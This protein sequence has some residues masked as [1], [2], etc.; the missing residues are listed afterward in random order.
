[1]LVWNDL[2][3]QFDDLKQFNEGKSQRHSCPSSSVK[4]RQEDQDKKL[5]V[6]LNDLKHE[7]DSK[8]DALR[9]DFS[10][11]T[12]STQKSIAACKSQI[13]ELFE[14]FKVHNVGLNRS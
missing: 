3:R 9:Q 7:L 8:F 10:E 11:Q 4:Y 6:M 1:M 13:N 14:L 5:N 12:S 2:K